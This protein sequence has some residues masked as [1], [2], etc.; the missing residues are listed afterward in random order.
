M[1]REIHVKHAE[2]SLRAST[3]LLCDRMQNVRS[4]LQLTTRRRRIPVL[5]ASPAQF[6]RL[7][8]SAGRQRG[9]NRRVGWAVSSAESAVSFHYRAALMVLAAAVHKGRRVLKGR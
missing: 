3:C 6:P 5:S 1:A 9:A 4:A 7:D 2:K 8:C